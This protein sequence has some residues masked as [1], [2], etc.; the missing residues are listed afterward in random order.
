[1]QDIGGWIT[2]VLISPGLEEEDILFHVCLT[3]SYV[4]YILTSLAWVLQVSEKENLPSIQPLTVPHVCYQ[5]NISRV[6]H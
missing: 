5:K 3:K 2:P 6:L 4:I 1:M